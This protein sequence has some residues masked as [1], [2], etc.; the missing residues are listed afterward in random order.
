MYQILII[1][2]VVIAIVAGDCQIRN[3]GSYLHVDCSNRGLTTVPQDLPLNTSRLDLSYNNISHLGASSFKYLRKLIVLNITKAEVQNLSER[4]FDGLYDLE[5]L[6]LVYNPGRR[7]M[8]LKILHSCSK[9]RRL[10]IMNGYRRPVDMRLLR[11]L[12][13]L[14]YLALD[15]QPLNLHELLKLRSLH[16][17]IC[18]QCYTK[19]TRTLMMPF[20]KMRITELGLLGPNLRSIENGTFNE[21]KYLSVLNFA[22]AAFLLVD[23]II[24]A[25]SISPNLKVNKLILDFV[26]THRHYW[27]LGPRD[28]PKCRSTWKYIQHLS[29][30][31]VHLSVITSGFVKCLSNLVT[32]SIGFNNM[33]LADHSIGLVAAGL[34][35]L[36]SIDV[37][38]GFVDDDINVAMA[39]NS[40]ARQT[41]DYF[42]PVIDATNCSIRNISYPIVTTEE[43]KNLIRHVNQCIPQCLSYININHFGLLPSHSRTCTVLPTNN[44]QVMNLSYIG[45]DNVIIRKPIFGLEVLRVLDVTS[46][47][48]ASIPTDIAKYVPDLTTLKAGKQ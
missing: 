19:L 11:G 1:S 46:S 45:F 18:V 38:Y 35:N 37:S 48:I 27:N 22:D 36:R 14:E 40:W 2:C 4:A 13:H 30:R 15:S 47:S 41:D 24:D 9:L 28:T 7:T 16:Q 32:L 21:F 39:W 10:S 42:P 6:C 25:M 29:M 17:I 26:N 12:D 23:D 33:L 8:S 20:S 43:C 44:L 31:G 3:S 34:H 5:E